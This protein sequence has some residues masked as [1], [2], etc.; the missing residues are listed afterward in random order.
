MVV[1]TALAFAVLADFES[2]GD[3][4]LRIL[5]LPVVSMRQFNAVGWLAL[6]QTAAGVVVLGQGGVGLVTFAQGGVGAIFGLGQGMLGLV[7]PLAQMGIGLFYFTG[8]MGFGLQARGQGVFIR[9]PSEYF[10]EIHAELDDM[11]R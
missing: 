8:Q 10:K 1:G 4:Y 6:G 11:L 9:K 2:N 5:D 7:V 3:S